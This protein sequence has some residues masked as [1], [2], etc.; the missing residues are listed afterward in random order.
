M[1]EARAAS[2]LC[3]RWEALSEAALNAYLAGDQDSCQRDWSAARRLADG[4]PAD[5]PRRACSCNNGGIAAYLAGDFD[6]ARHL[7]TKAEGLWQQARRWC[8]GM[9]VDSRARSSL[10]H[11]RLERKYRADYGCILRRRFK[12]L[13][14]GA[15]AASRFNG[16]MALDC[17]SCTS[18]DTLRR[19]IH[20]REAAFGPRSPD[21]LPMLTR[22]CALLQG[23]GEGLAT[24]PYVDRY[25]QI[26][27]DP[28]R[29]A[30][31]YWAEERP[32]QMTDS[33]RALAAVALTALLHPPA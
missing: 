18:V 12:R 11:L 19:A 1:D 21:L 9:S 8:D 33:R 15:A 27:I 3:H 17:R 22:L 29:R 32:P 5:D 10:F 25:A 20:D 28:S 2:A 31:E 13:V 23:K 24:Q 26:L 16:L 30:I 6:S 4:F 7:F 14:A